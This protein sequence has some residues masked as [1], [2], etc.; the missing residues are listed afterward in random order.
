[1][2]GEPGVRAEGWLEK[3]SPHFVW[4]KRW[5]SVDVK[6][7]ECRYYKFAGS[8]GERG[9]F[10]L[11]ALRMHDDELDAIISFEAWQ[12][13]KTRMKHFKLR[14]QTPRDALAWRALLEQA[15]QSRERAVSAGESRGESLYAS[16]EAVRHLPAKVIAAR[17]LSD[18]PSCS[19]GAR[20]GNVVTLEIETSKPVFVAEAHIAN[21]WCRDV[22]GEDCSWRIA[23][24]LHEG[25]M[26]GPVGFC[27]RFADEAGG[28]PG[29][30]TC[31]DL[32]GEDEE[33]VRFFAT[34]PRLLACRLFSSN[35][36]QT[37][38]CTSGDTMHLSLVASQHLARVWVT[39]CGRPATV[40]GADD[41]WEAK[42][43]VN[44]VGG[45]ATTGPVPFSVEVENAA[46]LRAP[47][48][49]QPIGQDLE[50]LCLQLDWQL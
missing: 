41:C 17:M 34:P 20:A 8:G 45:G 31:S 37:K 35:A 49:T 40:S 50:P 16:P 38:V 12:P 30:E 9:R 14:A 6:A 42:L 28:A 36:N 39:L 23:Q 10:K 27:V 47:A 32:M 24:M 43:S 22:S 4:Q 1:M 29:A 26:E 3:L 44:E 5:F 2:E 46:G 13:G 21:R 7:G 19:K 11:E 48:I 18:N 25:E 33:P 15:V